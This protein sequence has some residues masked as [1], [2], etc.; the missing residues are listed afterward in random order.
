MSL[1]SQTLSKEQNADVN[2][3]EEDERT[4]RSLTSFF[5]FVSRSCER[6]PVEKERKGAK[7]SDDDG[8]ETETSDKLHDDPQGEASK[9]KD[10]REDVLRET[11]G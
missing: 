11:K 9:E 4:R 7:K 5:F 2:T 6:L 8:D 3:E 1:K 10:G